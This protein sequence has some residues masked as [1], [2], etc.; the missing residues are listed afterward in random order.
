MPS[1]YVRSRTVPMARPKREFA[2]SATTRYFARTGSVAPSR[3]I[4]APV[5]SPS[6]INGATASAPDHRVAP[7]FTARS[8][9]ISS[10]S[11]RRT[12]YP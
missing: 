3:L 6:S 5:T 12:T 7:T 9:T 4:A 10:R 11:R 1:G 2:P 8:A